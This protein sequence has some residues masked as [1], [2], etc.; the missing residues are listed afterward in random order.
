MGLSCW[1]FLVFFFLGSDVDAIPTSHQEIH[2]ARK[3]RQNRCS[4]RAPKRMHKQYTNIFVANVNNVCTN[5]RIPLNPKKTTQLF[6]SLGSRVSPP[7]TVLPTSFGNRLDN[8]VSLPRTRSRNRVVKGCSP[9]IQTCG[10][11]PKTNKGAQRPS[12]KQP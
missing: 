1:R 9:R 11:C 10:F 12:S 4:K 7:Q 2:F 6:H 5:C 8:E 3:G